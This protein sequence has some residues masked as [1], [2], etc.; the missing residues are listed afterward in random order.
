MALIALGVALAWSIIE[1]GGNTFGAYQSLYYLAFFRVGFSYIAGIILARIWRERGSSL[2]VP[3]P[4]VLAIPLVV[5]IAIELLPLW[6]GEMVAVMLA[7]PL[8]IWLGASSPAPARSVG[9]LSW[10]GAISY[11]LYATHGPLIVFQTQL[12]PTLPGK[13]AVAAFAIVFAAIVALV[14]ERQ[15]LQR[16]LREAEASSTHRGD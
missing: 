11:P 6:L 13:F 1:V 12:W 9:A 7:W 4:V 2:A 14:L 10:L 3:W 15:R 8:V 16:R 5:L